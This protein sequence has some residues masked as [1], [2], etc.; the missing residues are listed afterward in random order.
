MAGDNPF[1][2]KEV[3]AAVQTEITN[4]AKNRIKWSPLRFPW[5]QVVSMSDLCGDKYSILSSGTGDSYESDTFQRPNV[6]ITGLDVK[7]Q[8]ELGTTRKGTIKMTAFTDEQ[9]VELQKC[10]FIPGMS[11]RVEWGWSAPGDLGAKKTIPAGVKRTASDSE[12]N[13]LMKVR[14]SGDP[15]Y[16][17]LQGIVANFSYTLT[18]DSY[19]ECTVEIIAAAEAFSKSKV[20]DYSCPECVGKHKDE[21]DK[22]T[23]QKTSSLYNYFFSLFDDF[24]K[25]VSTYTPAISATA[26]LDGRTIQQLQYEFNAAG[27]NE[28]GGEKVSM[29]EWM[30]PD[31]LVTPDTTEPFISFATLEAAINTFSIPTASNTY[32]FGR[33]VSNKMPITYHRSATSGDPRVCILPGTFTDAGTFQTAKPKAGGGASVIGIDANGKIAIMLDNILLNVTMLMIDLKKADTEG[34]GSLSTYLLGILGKVN[35]ACGGLWEFDIVSTSS[36]D[37]AGSEKYPTLT[38]VDTKMAAKGAAASTYL[39]PSLASNSVLRE[40]KLDLKLTDSMKTQ[41]LYANVDGVSQVNKTAAGGSCGESGFKLFRQ[42]SVKNLALSSTPTADPPKCKECSDFNDG[43]AVPEL[44]DLVANL[45]EAVTDE[46]STAV[47]SKLTEIYGKDAKT[48]GSDEHCQGMPVPF[49][50]NCTMDGIG[51]FVFGQLISCDRIPI[52]I[53]ENFDFQVTSVEHAVTINDWSTTVNTI[54]RTRPK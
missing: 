48:P 2:K 16:E 36:D 13:R 27:R 8:G 29:W 3:P 26:A 9:V 38:V 14:A 35:D 32:I 11:V 49:E 5:I 20:N 21:N 53:R 15:N 28:A 6:V 17:G 33:V 39:I 44:G 22:E 31:S 37:I 4:R 47:K 1:R 52:G 41:A 23:I 50:F 45:K 24:D 10:Y 19:W 7:K 34:D 25:A 46:S 40:M 30:T 51:G 43:E 54:A 18:R 42:G 12:A